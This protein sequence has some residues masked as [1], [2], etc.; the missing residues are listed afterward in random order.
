M[1][2]KIEHLESPSL[3]DEEHDELSKI[4]FQ[5]EDKRSGTFLIRDQKV[6][7][8]HSHKK[9]IQILP[10]SQA[11]VDYPEVQ[12]LM[13]GLIDSNENEYVKRVA[14]QIKKPLG[15]FLRVSKGQKVKLPLQ[16]YFMLNT[17]QLSQYIHNVLV[18]EKN[19]QVE[20]VGGSTTETQ[21]HSGTHICINEAY[22]HDNAVLKE[23][24]IEKWGS[25]VEVYNFGVSK[26]GKKAKVMS[27]NIMMTPVKIH[28]SEPRSFVD[29]NGLSQET[30]VI[31]APKGSNFVKGGK[32]HLQGKGA[33]ADIKS[34]TVSA[35]GNVTTKTTIIGEAHGAKGFNGCYGLKLTDEGNILTTPGLEA[36]TKGLDLSH[37]SSVGM[38]NQKKLSYLMASGMSKDSARDLIIK[39]FLKLETL[40][41]PKAIRDD[42]EKVIAA[43]KSGGM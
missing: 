36:K 40:K 10:I 23:T 38:I 4:G 18:I 19:A 39:G 43:A 14:K 35:G 26:I 30:T 16:V 17:P 22:V 20:I 32:V 42:V 13:F 21:V 25:N 31:F 8:S 11:V 41:I 27:T 2:K 5:H 12:D 33:T 6:L 9:G 1:V 34:R 7:Y 3:T 24:S 37:E 29:Q 28:Y 15:Y